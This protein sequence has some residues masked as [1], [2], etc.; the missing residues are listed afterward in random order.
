MMSEAGKFQTVP[1]DE[2]NSIKGVKRAPDGPSVFRRRLVQVSKPLFAVLLLMLVSVNVLK[3]GGSKGGDDNT[4]NIEDDVSIQRSQ[5]PPTTVTPDMFDASH[6]DTERSDMILHNFDKQPGLGT[7][8]SIIKIETESSF[9]LSGMYFSSD[10]ETKLEM[11]MSVEQNDD[12]DGYFTVD[13]NV[14]RLQMSGEQMGMSLDYD[15]D[16]DENNPILAKGLEGVVGSEKNILV[17]QDFAIIQLDESEC[18]LHSG[19]QQHEDQTTGLTASDQF[20]SIS[21]M[22]QAIPDYPVKAGDEWTF[23]MDAGLLFETKAQ[24]L[25]YVDYDGNDCA[26]ISM[27]GDFQGSLDDTISVT[28]DEVMNMLKS[29]NIE[30]GTMTSVLF[31]DNEMSISRWSSIE[32][33]YVISMPNPIDELQTLVI[34]TSQK[35]STYTGSK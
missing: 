11:E 26:V 8:V 6:L 5:W 9:E 1:Q 33:D 15:S 25:G 35:I 28:D 34:P 23:Q 18:D 22:M 21:R 13:L 16:S 32:M 19:M 17:D 7:Y 24:L 12:E 20:E 30:E 3:R 10:T 29:T 14:T 31:W 4:P 27:T 2:E